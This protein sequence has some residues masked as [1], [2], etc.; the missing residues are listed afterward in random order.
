[1]TTDTTQKLWTFQNM[2]CIN[3]E[4]H[5]SGFIIS[6]AHRLGDAGMKHEPLATVAVFMAIKKGVW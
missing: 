5:T 1:M 4:V 2:Q 3:C 6:V